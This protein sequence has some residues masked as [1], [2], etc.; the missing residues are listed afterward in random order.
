MSATRP[1]EQLL[2]DLLPELAAE[3]LLCNTAGRGQFAQ[4]WQQ[5][6]PEGRAVCHFFELY[7]HEQTAAELHSSGS[8]VE[9]VIAADLPAA[10]VDLVAFAFGKTG[11]AELVR[12]L[13]QQGH[14]RLALGGR[15]VAAS[16]NP[17]DQWLHE[18]LQR[19]FPKVTRK[20]FPTGVVYLATKRGP[21]KKLKSFGCEFSY[22]EE[23]C[24]IKLRT[25]P[26]VFSHREL[27]GGARA[28][29][30]AM[31]IEAA[32]S[33][34]DLGC[35]C[36][37]VGLVAAARNRQG[38]VLAI[39]SHVRAVEATRWGAEANELSNLQAVLNADGGSA[40]SE[41]Y[42]AVLANP[43]YYSNQRIAEIFVSTALRALRPGGYL[44]LVT[45]RPEW[46]AEQLP[47]RFATVDFLQVRSYMVV[48]ARKG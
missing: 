45:K 21:L 39:D 36:G 23:N 7:Q 13:L 5:F 34:L 6:Y 24:E 48:R 40:E 18:L 42:A 2:I 27:D 44:W 8:A 16:D 47:T 4:A 19:L 41:A 3:R 43:P 14:E 26:G 32:D 1:H 37:V 35:G 29:I 15:L 33:I 46:Y 9:T 25:R 17:R 12:D 38:K 11:E 10:M 22:R 30:E 28:L 31:E 20:V